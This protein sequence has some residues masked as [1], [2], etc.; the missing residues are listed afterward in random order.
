MKM[1]IAKETNDIG[2][3]DESCH[4]ACSEGWIRQSKPY[5]AAPPSSYTA[6]QVALAAVGA[7][8]VVLVAGGQAGEVVGCNNHAL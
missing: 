4:D 5:N 1:S 6:D 8:G 3:N 2:Y 7:V